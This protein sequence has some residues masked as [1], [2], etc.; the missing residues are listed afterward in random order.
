MENSTRKMIGSSIMVPFFVC[1]CY[2]GVYFVDFKVCVE[3]FWPNVF[4]CAMGHRIYP[5]VFQFNN[6]NSLKAKK[7]VAIVVSNLKEKTR[8]NYT[9]GPCGLC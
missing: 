6:T 7:I 8:V 2:L 1:E 9:N 4:T 5:T 3:G